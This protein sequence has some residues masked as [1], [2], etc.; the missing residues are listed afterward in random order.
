MSR[1]TP[2]SVTGALILG[3][4]LLTGCGE[5]K[6]GAEGLSYMT[7]GETYAEQ[8]QYRSAMLEIKNAIQQDPGNIHY[9][10]GLADIY[11]TIGANSE[12]SD[13][14]APW[15]KNNPD[16]VGLKLARA[17]LGQ[18]KH[19][20]ARETL[21]K[22]R[23]DSK[24]DRVLAM[25]L[26]GEALRLSRSHEKA[27]EA[28]DQALALQPSDQL[29]T[30]GKIRTYMALNNPVVATEIA[31]KWLAANG[32]DA[33]ILLLKG[34][35]LY[36]RN[37][38]E[39]SSE[40]LTQAIS[41]LPTADYF[42]PL[43]RD[44]LSL[45]SR[46]L[47]E[48]GKIT[49]AQVYNRVLSENSNSEAE[50]QAKA[51][52][53]AIREERF[54]EAAETLKDLHQLNPDNARIGLTLGALNLHQGNL[55]E[56]LSLLENN[57][58]PETSPAEFI[59]LT[60]LARIDQGDRRSALETLARA[61]DA[62]PN[63]PELITMHGLVALSLPGYEQEGLASISKALS[64]QP[65]NVRL[66]LVLARYYQGKGQTEQ[67]LGQ[68][69]MAFATKPDEWATTSS[70]LNLLIQNNHQE[71]IAELR[72]SLLNGYPDE[73][74]ARLLANIAL[75][76]LGG[77]D[78]AVANLRQL[79]EEDPADSA[80]HT[81]LARLYVSSGQ[82]VKAAEALVEAARN[83]PVPIVPLK[84]AASLYARSKGRGQAL[85][86]WMHGISRNSPELGSDIRALEI[87][88]D[89]QRGNLAHA[90]TLM[91]SVSPPEQTEAIRQAGT[92]LLIAE[93]MAAARDG[94]WA[95]AMEASA[96]AVALEPG[97]MNALLT[98]VRIQI[99]KG[100]M[101]QAS[102]DLD[103]IESRLGNPLPVILTRAEIM[104]ARGDTTGAFRY[105]EGLWQESPNPAVM[106]HLLRLAGK[107]A[108]EQRAELARQ[109][110]RLQPDNPAAQMA[111]ADDLLKSGD[112]SQAAAL[113]EKVLS[114]QPDYVP[115]LNNLAW[116]LRQGNL[117]RALELSSQALA[118]APGDA[119]VLDTHG[120]LLHLD[121]QH[122]LALNHL[123]QALEKMPDNLEIR[124]HLNTVKSLL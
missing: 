26:K 45:I 18:G 123:E 111:V 77:H 33:E 29:A 2:P 20:S 42:L 101:E 108:P 69:R 1:Y 109:W 105:L 58:D 36:H 76:A 46:V 49:E 56:G 84:Q 92:S 119:S 62:R 124:Q 98:P 70:Y 115:A 22:T 121:G 100:E 66:R 14:L 27:L 73:R 8:G 32:P 94:N 71:E 19:L 23:P 53:T 10:L 75:N 12:A 102:K 90:R 86:D 67:A 24:Q 25:A 4:L 97:N 103:A 21:D 107:A 55:S 72:D 91:D 41:E 61:A 50:Q 116:L 5:D 51:A 82:P 99:L 88:V 3:L 54:E 16:Q 40:V 6:D 93:A 13:L 118:L 11:L 38:L 85:T 7:R 52:M 78:K 57:L 48:Q 30:A 120:W 113:Y 64:L 112:N 15:M 39:E 80:V 17:Y 43:R 65:G 87:L 104:E 63:D 114:R 34:Q 60:T 59:R 9:I 37:R 35:A 83:T 96:Q 89:V 122:Q 74:P 110:L 79:L 47:T 68:L 28:F 44:A 117:E 31:D 95:K 81:A 106:P